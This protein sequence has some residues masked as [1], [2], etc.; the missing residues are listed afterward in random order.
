MLEY[1]G[2]MITSINILGMGAYPI[3]LSM[4]IG[5]SILLS[6]KRLG[7]MLVLTGIMNLVLGIG[8]FIG[9]KNFNYLI[10]SGLVSIIIFMLPGKK[11]AEEE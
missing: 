6:E 2:T 9:T 10:A 11:K 7:E 1:F 5:L 3:L 4:I 8:V